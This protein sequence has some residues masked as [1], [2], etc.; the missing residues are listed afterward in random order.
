LRLLLLLVLLLHHP[1][2]L[3]HREG[4]RRI[5][6]CS[7]WLWLLRNRSVLRLLLLL[8]PAQLGLLHVHLRHCGR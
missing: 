5:H 7:R 3:R 8:Q 1:V 2:R 6:R 4:R